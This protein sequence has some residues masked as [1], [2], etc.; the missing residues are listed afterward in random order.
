MILAF[1]T[2]MMEQKKQDYGHVLGEGSMK[3][4]KKG[5]QNVSS[6]MENLNL[7]SEA[8]ELDTPDGKQT[9][10]ASRI[11]YRILQVRLSH[12]YYKPFI[13]FGLTTT[14]LFL[15]PL[16]IFILCINKFV[17][18]YF[19]CIFDNPSAAINV[20]L[21]SSSKPEIPTIIGSAFEVE[22]ERKSALNYFKDGC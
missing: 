20:N 7:K 19:G 1:P 15:F 13:L 17:S 6:R 2:L 10:F 9:V 14:N 22:A 4:P 3:H 16:D 21:L 8:F 11:C 5:S 12:E 18:H